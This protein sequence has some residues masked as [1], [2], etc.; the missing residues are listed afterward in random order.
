MTVE[1]MARVSYTELKEPSQFDSN[2]YDGIPSGES[3]EGEDESDEQPE[4]SK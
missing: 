1:D 4:E 2:D 3:E